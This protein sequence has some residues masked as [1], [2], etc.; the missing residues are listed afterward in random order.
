MPF[1]YESIGTFEQFGETVQ[2]AIFSEL[3]TWLA[4]KRFNLHYLF[5]AK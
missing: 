4:K 2:P 1:F 5:D 3:L